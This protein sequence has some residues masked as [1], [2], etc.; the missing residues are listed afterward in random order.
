MPSPTLIAMALTMAGSYANAK[1]NQA[2]ALARQQRLRELNR[3]QNIASQRTQN[4]LLANLH[5]FSGKEGQRKRNEARENALEA[6]EKV[7]AI[8]SPIRRGQDNLGIAGK[9]SSAKTKR[10]RVD[11]AR[12][13]RENALRNEA[14]AN[15]LGIAGGEVK[16][17]RQLSRMGQALNQLR[18]DAKGQLAVDQA[19]VAHSP[20]ANLTLG[21]L[22]K[23]AGTAV[24]F[25]GMGAGPMDGASSAAISKAD[26][27][28][29]L[30]DT[31]T[32]GGNWLGQTG[33]S[34]GT[35]IAGSGAINYT[36]SFFNAPTS[37]FGAKWVQSAP[38]FKFGNLIPR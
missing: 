34:A 6:I 27:A 24:G 3:N 18:T 14:L 10:N 36:P 37:Q 20:T 7:S 13:A 8:A 5:R 1:A 11:L 12:E 16:T 30:G 4:E 35:N 9:V 32:S 22:L 26:A 25:A 15:F 2:A 21:N 19:R 31:A 29:T 17:G 33:G 28:R 23:A 38:T